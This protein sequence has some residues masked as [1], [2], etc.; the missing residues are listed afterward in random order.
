VKVFSVKLSNC[1]K[2]L[3]HLKYVFVYAPLN[4]DYSIK[5]NLTCSFF[6]LL[7]TRTTCL[8]AASAH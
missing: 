8:H 2:L 5:D 7:W 1:N 6:P 3:K 4:T